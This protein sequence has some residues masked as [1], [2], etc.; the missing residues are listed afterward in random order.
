ME[1]NDKKIL[2]TS[3]VKDMEKGKYNTHHPLQR[4]EGQW[5]LYDKSL[6]IDSVLR[7][8][9]ID[10]IRVQEKEDKIKYIFD[11]VQRSTTFR[12]FLSDEFALSKKLDPV[13]IEGETY[14]IAGKKY[15]QLDEEVKDKID[16][17]AIIVYIFSDCT[18]EDIKEMFRRQNNGK[19]LSN[20]QKRKVFESKNVSEI[21][22]ELATHP[23][24]DKILT[25]AQ[26]KK[27]AANDMV[28]QTL[29]LINSTEEHDFTSF[30]AKDIDAFVIWYD[31]NI[32]END[33]NILKSA[34][35]FLND[36]IE[37]LS[38]KTTSIPMM[39]WAAYEVIKEGKDFDLFIAKVV[40]FTV[41]YTDNL[42]YIALCSGTTSHTSV[43]GRF[44]YW[45]NIVASLTEE[46]T[47]E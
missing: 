44:D 27:D 12:D 3:F 38:I 32:N 30:R 33:L 34:L 16:N 7:N 11:G 5:K 43:H 18:D 41:N 15:S 22:Y 45:K 8:Y 14:I 46:S 6:L 4:R 13:I 20:T 25:E 47:E 26:I 39:L 9:P 40:N 28:R 17:N 37:E 24:F 2:T 31:Q 1:R 35:E 29:M 36:G 19:P 21:I 10:P 23:L 42:D